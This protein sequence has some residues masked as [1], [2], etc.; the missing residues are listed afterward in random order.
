M[1]GRRVKTLSLVRIRQIST[2]RMAAGEDPRPAVENDIMH[3]DATLDVDPDTE[4]ALGELS[5]ADFRSLS[6]VCLRALW[7]GGKKRARSQPY[8]LV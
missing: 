7:R 2:L 4:E 6:E 3:P 8:P 5:A 1:L